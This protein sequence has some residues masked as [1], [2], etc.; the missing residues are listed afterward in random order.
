MRY[1][2]R[3]RTIEAVSE[4]GLE[5]CVGGIPNL[6][7][8]PRQRVE[9]AFELSEIDPTTVPINL[10][11]PRTGTKFG[12]RDLMDPWEVV[13]WMAI[14]R[15]ILPG[16]LFRLCG[17]RVENLGGAAAAGGQG[18]PERG[19]DGQLP[20]D[21]RRRAGRRPRD[22]RGARP[23]TWRASPT[24]ARTRAPTTAA[25]GSRARPSRRRFDE[26]I[27]GQARGHLWDPSTQLRV[28]KKKGRP[29]SERPSERAPE[30]AGGSD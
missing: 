23:G 29:L 16:A 15:L 24:T 12:D 10:L 8:T 18:G 20:D 14:F 21:P 17:G 28:I 4:A 22:V 30:P 25:A 3:L 6:G 27:D 19:D 7:E 5:S 9:M 26:L 11:N 2:G 13:K 1:E